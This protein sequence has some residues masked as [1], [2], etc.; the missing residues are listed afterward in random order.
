MGF[1]HQLALRDRLTKGTLDFT[2]INPGK[3]GLMLAI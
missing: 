1:V 3:K 2:L